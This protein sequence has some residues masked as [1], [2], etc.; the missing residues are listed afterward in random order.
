M[1]TLDRETKHSIFQ[2]DARRLAEVVAPRS[3][4]LVVTSPP[5]WNLKAYAQN[6]GQLG[7]LNDYESFLS[8]LDKVWKG[9]F[10]ALV[11]GGRMCVVV[12]DVCLSRRRNGRHC[13]IPLHADIQVHARHVGF[14]TLAP[15]IWHKIANCRTE[16]DRPSYFLGKPYE[17]NAIIKNDIEF[18]LLFRKAGE[19]RH[20]TEEQRGRSRLSRQ[21]FSTFFQQ[22]W[23]IKGASTRRH[24]A[25]FPEELANR[26]IRMFSFEGDTV[27]DP[28][29]GTGTTS[30]AA[31]KTGR[32]SIG[33]EIDQQY[34]W[35]CQERL[36]PMLFDRTTVKFTSIEK[37][38]YPSH[39]T[40]RPGPSGV[41][42]HVRPLQPASAARARSRR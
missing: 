24:P 9:C 41:A 33:I 3:V 30:L 32:S 10:E 23:D 2:G 8:E 29:L 13:V 25:P 7:N 12:G 20:P 6:N 15:I 18:I 34:I 5:Y 21:E 27:L 28:F 39:E 37:P 22:I 26:L 17:P 31:M 19:Y 14:D 38:G 40:A 35:I 4:H 36:G 42:E 1:R 16:M 11:P